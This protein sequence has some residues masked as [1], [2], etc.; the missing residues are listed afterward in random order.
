[1]P[2]P[3]FWRNL[4]LFLYRTQYL[5]RTLQFVVGRLSPATSS[6]G[7]AGLRGETHV[8]TSPVKAPTHSAENTQPAVM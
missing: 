6:A 4:V 5:V 8:F 1:M 7:S 3:R 2:V